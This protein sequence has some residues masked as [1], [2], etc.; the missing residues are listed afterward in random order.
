MSSHTEFT[1]SELKGLKELMEKY[2]VQHHEDS[3]KILEL[4]KKCYEQ[5]VKIVSLEEK[6]KCLMKNPSNVFLQI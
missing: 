2:T 1:K 4:T 6:I 3:K 5:H